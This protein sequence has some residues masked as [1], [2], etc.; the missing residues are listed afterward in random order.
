MRT[1]YRE[2]RTQMAVVAILAIGTCASSQGP[3]WSAIYER[4][5]GSVVIVEADKASGTYVGSGFLVLDSHHVVTCFHVIQGARSLTVKGG[6]GFE[7]GVWKV[8]ADQRNDLAVL[9]LLTGKE[10]AKPIPLGDKVELKVGDSV[11]L[12]GSPTGV[13]DESLSTGI[14]SALRDVDG[15]R[16]VQTTAAASHGSSGSPLLD[17]EGRVVGVLSFRLK[18]GESFPLCI[19]ATHVRALLDSA[20]YV[21]IRDV[22]ADR[23]RPLSDD[24]AAGRAACSSAFA[25]IIGAAVVLEAEVLIHLWSAGEITGADMLTLYV[26]RFDNRVAAHLAAGGFSHADRVAILEAVFRYKKC[27][28]DYYFAYWLSDIKARYGSQRELDEANAK[29]ADEWGRLHEAK[30]ALSKVGTKAQWFDV[31]VFYKSLEPFA[32]SVSIRSFHGPLIAD[33]DFQDICMIG[34]AGKSTKL[35]RGDVIV[36]V[37]GKPVSNWKEFFDTARDKTTVVVKTRSGKVVS[38]TRDGDDDDLRPLV[39][40]LGCDRRA[41]HNADP[42]GLT[43]CYA[44]ASW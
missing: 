44:V 4:L 25:A 6:G 43:R 18:G 33:P 5:R 3:E 20:A 19:S 29:A 1:L 35:R 39:W 15:T 22:S 11:G 41:E 16:L 7:S 34:Y 21:D 31:Q 38:L 14:V 2:L 17:G 40:R 32:F 8:A 30:S 13:L 37:D 23:E 36:D 12:I 42:Q 10:G 28:T 9:D 26:D 24:A 27:L